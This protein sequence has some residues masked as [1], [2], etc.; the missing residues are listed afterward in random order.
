M[1]LGNRAAYSPQPITE[2]E[3]GRM[4]EAYLEMKKRA[5]RKK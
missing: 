1:E 5:G 3:R 4:Q 2:E